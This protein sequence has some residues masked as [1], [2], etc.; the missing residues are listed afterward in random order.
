VFGGI[1]YILYNVGN[2]PE[3]CGTLAYISL[4]VEILP[5]TETLNF[6]WEQKELISLSRLIEHFSLDNLHSKIMFHVASKAFSIS[7]NTAAVD[8]ADLPCDLLTS[9]LTKAIQM[10]EMSRLVWLNGLVKHAICA[11][12]LYFLY[13]LLLSISKILASSQPTLW[14]S[15]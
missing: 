10:G 2:R 12:S 9:L 15:S 1:I 6:L 5:S 13:L 7:K 14:P 3:P 8:P 11:D 4:G